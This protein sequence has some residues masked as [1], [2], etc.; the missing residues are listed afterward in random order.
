MKRYVIGALAL[1]VSASFLTAG[2]AKK[3]KKKKVEAVVE[4]PAP[5]SLVSASDS[6]SYAAGMSMTNG[7]MPFL[8]QQFNFN[9]AYMDDFIEGFKLF[10][11]TKDDPKAK[12]KWWEVQQIVNNPLT[13]KRDGYLVD[14]SKTPFSVVAIDD[15]EMSK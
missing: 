4:A 9:E 8:K 3:D 6:L 13:F 15:Y 14:R 10:M 5:V 7:L 11:Q 1:V 12:A 2:A